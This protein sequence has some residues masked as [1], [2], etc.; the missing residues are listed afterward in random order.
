MAAARLYVV[1]WE[2]L[3]SGILKLVRDARPDV[4]AV[5]E[6]GRISLI[7]FKECT[8][9]VLLATAPIAPFSPWVAL[10]GLRGGM[11]LR[12]LA[13]VRAAVPGAPPLIP[14]PI[15]WELWASPDEMRMAMYLCQTAIIQ[16]SE[17][18]KTLTPLRR[19]M[20]LFE[21][22]RTEFARL[23]GVTRQA[24][25]QWEERGVPSERRAKLT[26]LL[27]V[28][29]LLARKLRPQLLPGVARTKAEAYGG[30]T[31]LELIAADEHEWLL[32][33]VRES[34]DWAATA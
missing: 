11:A 27:A 6:E 24:I 17:Y 8:R 32:N 16:R 25:E 10:V 20:E 2:A 18:A 14:P 13:E 29:E 34:F 30:R 3:T 26:T 4:V 33:D 22:D 9:D 1:M 5:D 31:M 28:G 12:L 7:Q 15:K 19:V 23:F 21:L